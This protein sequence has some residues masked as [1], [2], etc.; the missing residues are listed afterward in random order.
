VLLLA[1]CLPLP[2]LSPCMLMWVLGRCLQLLL[3]AFRPL[4]S[5]LLL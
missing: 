1:P 4:L 3:L 5:R 2:R